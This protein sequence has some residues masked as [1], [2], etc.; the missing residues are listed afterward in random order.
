MRWPWSR[1]SSQDQL[2]VSWSGQT[3]AYVRARMVSGGQIEVGQV[4]VERQGTDTRDEFIDRLKAQGLG[5]LNASVMLRPEQCQ[6]L[7]TAA[8][9]VAPEEMRSAA[10]YQIREMVDI[11]I[12]DITLDVVYVGDGHDKSSGQM[13]VVTAANAVVREVMALAD[14]MQWPVTV[15][16]IQEMAQR[17][18]Q[19][20]LAQRAGMAERA[21]A[22]LLVTDER[23]A[24]L[25]ISAKGELYYT[26]R[27]D[28]PAGFMS[29]TWGQGG[30]AVA[31]EAFTPVSEYVPDYSPDSTGLG[32]EYQSGASLA[33]NDAD[34]VQRLVVEIQRSLDLWDRTWSG[35]PLNG[36]R[37]YAGERSAELANWLARETG[38][39]VT[40]IS[41]DALFPGVQGLPQDRAYCLPLLGAF[42]RD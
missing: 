29:M 28:L 18:L 21:E 40:V 2:V 41:V 38:Q 19:S 12:D 20:A 34:R 23:Q 39:T 9:A 36:L 31:A 24:V 25:T 26:R 11:H 13:F 37:V 1:V 6:V 14:A 16:D 35:K 22:V 8:P 42:L 27:L 10:R 4:G 3:L 5:G 17:N 7:Q 33:G 32:I 15:I 30:E